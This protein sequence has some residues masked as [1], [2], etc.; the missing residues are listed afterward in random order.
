[1]VC[2]KKREKKKIG[3]MDIR[4]RWKRKKEGGRRST[5]QDIHQLGALDPIHSINKWKNEFYELD[6][7]D[8]GASVR[9]RKQEEC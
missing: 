1:V 3:L 4:S 8:Q 5:Q 9:R 2:R 7:R 6:K